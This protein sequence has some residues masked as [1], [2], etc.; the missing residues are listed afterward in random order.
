MASGK[1]FLCAAIVLGS[2]GILLAADEP[3]TA[4][5]VAATQPIDAR[6][7]KA[8]KLVEPWSFIKTL[9]PDQV[10]Q[11]ESIHADAAEQ[12]KK[13]DKKENDDISALLTPDQIVELKEAV[14]K[15][16]LERKEKNAVRK[17]AATTEPTD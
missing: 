4:P 9:T 10:T 17:H 7:A 8:K 14:A 12:V 5:V 2:G 1:W 13:I 15:H 6:P 3:T 11:I 16:K